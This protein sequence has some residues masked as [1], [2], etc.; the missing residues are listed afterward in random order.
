MSTI[1]TDSELELNKKITFTIRDTECNSRVFGDCE[2]CNKMV[3]QIHHQIRYR[4]FLNP[5]TGVVGKIELS[6][7]YGHYQCL[8]DAR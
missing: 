5:I 4:E 2:I 6:S 7:G 3:V 1:K 8:L